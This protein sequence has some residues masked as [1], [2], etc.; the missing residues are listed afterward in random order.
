MTMI[1]VAFV[2]SLFMAFKSMPA[3]VSFFD[4]LHLAG[5]AG[6]LNIVDTHLDLSSR[7]NIW[8]GLIGGAFFAL[9][10]FGCDQSQ[11]QRYL[12]GKSI[13]QSR[14]SLIFNASVKIPMQLFILFIGAMVFV[15]SLF[16]QEPMIFHPFEAQRAAHSPE[17]NTAEARYEKAFAE[18]RDAAYALTASRRRKRRLVSNGAERF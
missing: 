3:H 11:V 16:V 6:R 13:A 14:L 2:V 10:Y 12:T 8:S 17:W 7:Y 9:A 15:L 4:A 18:R 1:F 5:A